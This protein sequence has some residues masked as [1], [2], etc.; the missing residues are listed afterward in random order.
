MKER[1]KKRAEKRPNSIEAPIKRE[2]SFVSPFW[3]YDVELQNTTL[4]PH[5]CLTWKKS[6]IAYKRF[7]YNH[8]NCFSPSH[9]WCFI[10]GPPS[11]SVE[12]NNSEE[13]VNKSTY[14]RKKLGA[15][16]ICVKYQNRESTQVTA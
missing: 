8:S 7:K 9:S 10:S 12:N 6:Y 5:L 3:R 15:N 13:D 1:I 14:L 4:W 16:R 2:Y 11:Y